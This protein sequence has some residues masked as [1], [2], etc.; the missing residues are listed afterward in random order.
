M[1]ALP[2]PPPTSFAK[3]DFWLAITTAV[4][5]LTLALVWLPM[6]HA[7]VPMPL[8]LLIAG[9]Y[10]AGLMLLSQWP[11]PWPRRWQLLGF[12]LSSSCA[13]LLIGCLQYGVVGIL[14]IIL[15][16]CAVELW[17]TRW[18]FALALAFP[19]VGGCLD[20]QLNQLADAWL[21]ALLYALFNCFAVLVSWR[22]Q[23]ERLLKE[24]YRWLHQQLLATQQLLAQTVKG[25]ERL[26]ISRDLH[27]IL[28]HQLTAIGLNL[29]LAKQQPAATQY[30]DQALM[31][32]RLLLS[33][34]RHV[35][36]DMRQPSLCQLGPALHTLCQ[37]LP[38]LTC[39][40][41]CNDQQLQLDPA[42]AEL[43]FRCAQEAITN[44]VKHSHASTL[45][46]H[47][48]QH[49]HYWQLTVTDNG[50]APAHWQYGNGLRGMQERLAERQG[51]LVIQ[52]D[53]GQRDTSQRDT[54]QRDAGTRVQVQLPKPSFTTEHDDTEHSD[55]K[56]DNT[57]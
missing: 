54:R 56:H 52:S 7:T 20:M 8:L 27:D 6:S 40:I 38:G 24:R 37:R 23:A 14:A 1:D 30:L 42:S 41:H 36:D 9:G 51:S 16:A 50:R 53:A 4:T 13:L 17:S 46:I 57:D 39:T 55:R 29:Q 28:G 44:T 21:N 31:L 12:V 11:K 19:L 18:A 48:Q 34:V 49:R 2:Q 22:W 45:V 32:N 43:L 47:L 35:V 25:D 5:V 10:L 26:R 3:W 33:D 15:C